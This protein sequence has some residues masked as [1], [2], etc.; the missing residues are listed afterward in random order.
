MKKL[1]CD[2]ITSKQVLADH[3]LVEGPI[4]SKR[5]TR[6]AFFKCSALVG[7]CAA[8]AAQVD[9]LSHLFIPGA[10]AAENEKF[11][12]YVLAQPQNMIYTTCLQCHTACQ[13]KMKFW[14]GALA[15]ISGNPYAPQDYLPHIL[16]I[17][18]PENTATIDGK[19]CPK[20]AAGIQTY[21]DP[22]RVRKVLKRDGER[23]SNRWKSIPFDQFITEV[24]QGGKLFSSAGDTR[25]YPGF[26]D[27]IVLKDAGLEQ[28]YGR[29]CQK[30]Q[31][32][33]HERPGL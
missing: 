32:G 24:S 2:E 27:I 18:D 26:K 31:Q 29:G 13:L 5:I 28:E 22:Y 25:D 8:L 3:N 14:D 1:T 12:P 15:K 17:P 16:T 20:G 33:R 21:Y 19:L 9:A 6:R 10:M 7:G 11:A 23:G 30:G 4:G